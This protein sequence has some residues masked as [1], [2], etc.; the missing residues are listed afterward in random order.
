MLEPHTPNTIPGHIQSA[1]LPETINGEEHFEINA[2]C[3]ST[4]IHHYR[5]P[6]HYLVEWKGYEETSEG[7][8]WVSTEDIQAPDTLA[9]FHTLNPDKPSPID[10]LVASDYR[11][12]HWSSVCRHT[13][14]GSHM[15]R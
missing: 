2:I 14:S 7:L 13:Y 1:P 5:M 12:G 15:T 3:N 9:D 4:I 10:K 11:G 6:L 8:E